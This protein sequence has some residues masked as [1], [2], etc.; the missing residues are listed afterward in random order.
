MNAD[1]GIDRKLKSQKVLC[2]HITT[3]P[4]S[5]QSDNGISY[6]VNGLLLPAVPLRLQGV[7]AVAGRTYHR[8]RQ[9]AGRPGGL[10]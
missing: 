2:V 10:G 6:I 4:S 3:S 7:H 5:S 1:H 9:I 8:A